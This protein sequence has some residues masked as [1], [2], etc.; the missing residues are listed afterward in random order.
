MAKV[1]WLALSA[2]SGI[3]GVTAKRLLERFGTIEAAIEA[4]VEE[5]GRVPRMTPDAIRQLQQVSLEVLEEQIA[6]LSE[7]GIEILT[8]DDADYPVNLRQA[9]DSPPVLFVKGGFRED[10]QAVAVVGTREPS[11]PACEAARRLALGLADRGI[12]VVS[13]LAL[14]IDTAAHRG[15]L[16]AQGGRTI[17]VLGCGLR[18]VHP[19]SNTALAREIVDRGALVSELQ[20]STP[21]QGRHLMARDRIIAGLSRIIVV[22][23]A[24][25]NSGSLDTAQKAVAQ[26]RLLYAMPGSEGTDDLIAKGARPIV[27]NNAALDDLAAATGTRLAREEPSQPSLW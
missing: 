20:P 7:E 23:E 21:I 15:A 13:G 2:V 4:P 22:V 12:T 11:A 6:D 17:A 10:E 14:G 25:L 18:H 9:A 19:R 16:E 3:G 1:H 8:W 27:P 5:L 26:G 24:G